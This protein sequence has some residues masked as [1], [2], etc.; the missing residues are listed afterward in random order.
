MW[1]SIVS[2]VE[3]PAQAQGPVGRARVRVQHLV[4]F[5]LNVVGLPYV[6]AFWW[7]GLA[8]A[9]AVLVA[10]ICLGTWGLFRR[11]RRG[12]TDVGGLVVAAGFFLTI[13][14]ALVA[15]GGM[16]SNSAA[17]LLLAPVLAFM[18]V[19][20]RHG[21]LVGM[22]TALEFVLL[23]AAEAAG[24]PFPEG[25]PAWAE[26]WMIIIDYPVIALS[27]SAIL[28]VQTG[29]WDGVIARLDAANGELEQQV[30][31]RK[32]AE[33]DALA[34]AQARYTFLA[35]MSHEIRTPLN[36]VLGLT[37]VLLETEMSDDQRQLAG[38]VKESGQ[39]LRSLLDDVLDFSKIDS[40]QLEI[41]AVP[42]DVT[43]L[44]EE[45]VRLWGARAWE[46][47]LELAVVVGEGAPRV[48]VGDPTR[49]RQILGNL[50]S[51]ALKFTDAGHVWI[52]IE[53]QGGLLRLSVQ[54]TGKGVAPEAMEHIF[55][56]FRQADSTTTRRHGGT[57]LGL[58]I[59]RRLATA[60]EGT[61]TV[62]STL[63]QGATFV[64]ELPLRTSDEEVAAPAQPE[65][66]A[67]LG[68]HRVLVAEDNPVNRM[69]IR[70][71]L[72]RHDVEVV[73]AEDGEV[74]VERWRDARP[75]LILMDCQMPLL[76]GYDATRRLRAQGATQPIVALTANTMPGDRARCLE[77]GMDDHL[78]K[79]VRPEE[80]A[81]A[82]G[83]WLGRVHA[84][85]ATPGA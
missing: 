31:V 56:P 9:A 54:D 79:P 41:E 27:V 29:I 81:E 53:A 23:W 44:A 80:L 21:V 22:A 48:V 64:L 3:A 62:R 85:G 77:A 73:M 39:L 26:H 11:T 69:V 15:R 76:D 37:D 36:G 4:V 50:V 25:L 30:Q 14:V 52:R 84:G 34:A 42:Y 5:L 18:M 8:E 70:R 6:A 33:R 43:A 20:P 47:R 35:T 45:V 68:G 7:L 49:L 71:L 60:M 46:R 83:K 10:V 24:V 57:G 19:G 51:N 32:Q 13:S 38:T 61:L 82:L 58:A 12:A 74:C 28:W 65:V 75:D 59:C 63:G 55:Q 1:R 67:Q 16:T 66:S 2:W 78:G 72:E 17:W 40:G